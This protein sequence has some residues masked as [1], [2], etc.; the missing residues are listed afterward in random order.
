MLRWLGRPAAA[1]YDPN[2]MP[3]FARSV[4]SLLAAAIAWG[5]AVV[6]QQPAGEGKT[7][8][9]VVVGDRGKGGGAESLQS[10]AEQ[11]ERHVPA[12]EE[13][14]GVAL[15][16]G[17]PVCRIQ[18]CRERSEAVAAM[19]AQLGRELV[20]AGGIDR[21]NGRI[22]VWDGPGGPG[23]RL[24]TLAAVAFWTERLLDPLDVDAAGAAWLV[25]GA[26]HLR[27][28]RSGET[29][30]CFL[31]RDA[32]FPFVRCH[33]GDFAT[34]AATMARSGRL[35]RLAALLQ[36]AGDDFD[37]DQHAAAVAL[38]GWLASQG[39]F[40]QTGQAEVRGA[41]A[42]QQVVAQLRAGKSAS[43][44]LAAVFREPLPDVERRWREALLAGHQPQEKQP[45]GDGPTERPTHP[46][47]SMFVY[48]REP[49]LPRHRRV[50]DA[51]LAARAASLTSAFR[52]VDGAPKVALGPV[53]RGANFW[54]R[55]R[56]GK[57]IDHAWPFVV[58]LEYEL[59]GGPQAFLDC[60]RR[61]TGSRHDG[62]WM[63]DP[64]V[65]YVEH[66]NQQLATDQDERFG[67]VA[68]PDTPTGTHVG[69]SEFVHRGRVRWA[70]GRVA[71]LGVWTQLEPLRQRAEA[72]WEAQH[73][74]LVDWRV[75]AR[76]AAAGATGC[77]PLQR[78]ERELAIW[79]TSRVLDL[80]E[81]PVGVRAGT[82]R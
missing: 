55:G 7:A 71:C 72:E 74:W 46:R 70:D 39:G 2:R 13:L 73:R 47:A 14:L 38:V 25:H 16:A 8:H 10:V 51:A 59:A 3:S 23:L 36:T 29:C 78:P 19:R 45:R 77:G 66:H 53:E 15:P 67:Y 35:P 44:A 50:V 79:G 41:T 12:L 4:C 63:L 5:P 9:L 37:F 82:G 56:L 49:V 81:V 58:V 61:A 30:D 17:A 62:G 1:G 27:L 57:P 40:G 64:N 54:K 43:E 76:S 33:G 68:I 42:L 6:A 60:F 18:L 32:L 80:P 52:T 24:A 21:A 28:L 34:A 20:G 75:T 69:G 31:V 26:A 22:V 11:L 48:V 65:G